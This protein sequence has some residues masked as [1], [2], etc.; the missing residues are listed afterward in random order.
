MISLFLWIA[1]KFLAIVQKAFT[2]QSEGSGRT[3]KL[4]FGPLEPKS[5][6]PHE[7]PSFR[8]QKYY[9]KEKLEKAKITEQKQM[10]NLTI[11][12]GKSIS[13]GTI[14]IATFNPHHSHISLK[15]WQRALL[16]LSQ[17]ANPERLRATKY[18]PMKTVA[19]CAFPA[20]KAP[21]IDRVLFHKM[22]S[23]PTFEWIL[24]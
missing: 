20:P 18:S 1:E 11:A 8:T 16:R 22:S 5:F 14:N 10:R 23:S 2:N 3:R 21:L 7:L 12:Q 6:D 4:C 19:P 24:A 13:I 17:L 9:T 15:L